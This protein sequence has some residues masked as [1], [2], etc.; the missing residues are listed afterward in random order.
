VETVNRTLDILEVFLKQPGEIGIAELSSLSGI[1]ISTAHR[2]ATDLVN[3][4][5]LKQK[6]KRGK[7]SIGVKPLEYFVVIQNSLKIGDIS[8]PYLK[9]LSE[10]SGE[11]VE[12]AILDS[13]S[14][15]TV[16]QVEVDRN[17]R[18][19]NIIGERLP[20]NATSLGKTFLAYMNDEDREAYFKN[21]NI[22]KF[23]E[24]SI[25][26][27]N[28]MNEEAIKIRNQGYAIDNQELD[29]G[30]WAISAPVF[31][32]NG[33]IVA[34]LSIAGPSARITPDKLNDCIRWI[35]DFAMDISREMGYNANSSHVADNK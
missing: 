34:G 28:K 23:T 19:S 11:Y 33:S 10:L 21:I 29:I 24:K 2:I 16:A 12:V 4:G 14:A 9:K 7:Y 18:I 31:D 6:I 35:Q 15:M 17:L 32:S 30:V 22:H 13:F 8:M 26:D 5:Y 1:N 20:L 3:R 27:I 25:T